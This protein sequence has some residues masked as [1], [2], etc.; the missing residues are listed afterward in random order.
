MEEHVLPRTGVTPS[1]GYSQ[2]VTPGYAPE[3]CPAYGPENTPG[4]VPGPSPG[5]VPGPSPGYA[6][7][8]TP[9]YVPGPSPGYAPAQTPGYVPGPSPGYAPEPTPV[10]NP[11]PF[12]PGGNEAIDCNRLPL[13]LSPII[14]AEGVVE[15]EVPLN[16]WDVI[17][18]ADTQ[19]IHNPAEIV[20]IPASP[21]YSRRWKMVDDDAIC[22]LEANGEVLARG[23]TCV[24]GTQGSLGTNMCHH[25]S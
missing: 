1:P 20:D 12:S 25:L 7:A 17:G 8:Q 23:P 24:K 21:E 15:I 6:P 9:G 13:G 14:P 22:I 11:L 2:A 19:I 18:M 3:L 5:Y 4:Y 16:T 10:F